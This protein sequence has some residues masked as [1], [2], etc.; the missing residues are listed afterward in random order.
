MKPIIILLFL[1][2]CKKETEPKPSDKRIEKQVKQL[3]GWENNAV[4]GECKK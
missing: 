1:F 3:Q 2:S 4:D